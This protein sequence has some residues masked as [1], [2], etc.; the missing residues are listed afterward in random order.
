MKNQYVGD[1]NDYRKYG[2]LRS[3]AQS[4]LRIGVCWMLTPDD[5][6]TD[7]NFTRYLKTAN[8]EHLDPQ[9]YKVL[10]NLRESARIKV[11]FIRSQ[12]VIPAAK[13]FDQV[14]TDDLLQRRKYFGQVISEFND[15][16]L[17]FLDPDNGIEVKSKKYGRKNSCKYVYWHELA[18]LYGLGFSLLVYQHFPR[19]RRDPFIREVSARMNHLFADA[20]IH[21]FKTSN[22]VFFLALQDFHLRCA[23]PSCEMINDKWKD[24]IT[25]ERISKR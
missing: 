25:Y 18:A 7:G 4:R 10:K 15:R 3:I 5:G 1:V 6:R 17:I 19:K 16:D 14:L 2:L 22:V 21:V 9:L 13:Y 8:F 11:R 23:Q 20:T 24:H 12:N